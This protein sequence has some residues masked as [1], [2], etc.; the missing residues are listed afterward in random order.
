MGR[1]GPVRWCAWQLAARARPSLGCIVCGSVLGAVLLAWTAKIGCDSGLSSA[2]LNQACAY[3]QYF[4]AAADRFNILQMIRMRPP[5]AGVM[6]ER[7]GSDRP[8][9]RRLRV[10]GW[11]LFATLLWGGLV[12]ALMSVR[13]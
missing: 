3:W 5:R 12:V 6:R 8:P 9:V 11:P 1:V 13:W 10:A 7:H 4:S 2:G